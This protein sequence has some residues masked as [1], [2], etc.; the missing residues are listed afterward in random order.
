MTREEMKSLTSISNIDNMFLSKIPSDDKFFVF[1][2][3]ILVENKE[4]NRYE[5]NEYMFELPKLKTLFAEQ[6][7][8]ERYID[9]LFDKYNLVEVLTDLDYTM[10]DFGET[11]KIPSIT[12]LKEKYPDKEIVINDYHG[13]VLDEYKSE[14]LPLEDIV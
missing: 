11:G 10:D 9:N 2:Y 12:K 5:I 14:R 1:L 8:W 3:P 4:K 6:H 13:F 7:R